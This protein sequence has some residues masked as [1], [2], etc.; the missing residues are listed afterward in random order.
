MRKNVVMLMVMVL[1]GV[2]V[3]LPASAAV[4]TITPQDPAANS[5]E[6]LFVK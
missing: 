1:L 2:L 5:S 4:G 6:V 3:A